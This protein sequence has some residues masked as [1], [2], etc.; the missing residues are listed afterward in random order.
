M[1]SVFKAQFFCHGCGLENTFD[2]C[3]QDDY[4]VAVQKATTFSCPSGCNPQEE[5]FE[6]LNLSEVGWESAVEA[7]D[8][9]FH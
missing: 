9:V 7:A 3:S 5:S 8:A 6:L 1:V 4:F 2:Y